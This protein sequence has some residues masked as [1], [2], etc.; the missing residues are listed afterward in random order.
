LDGLISPRGFQTCV[1]LG[2]TAE[3]A[4]VV[5]RVVV[6]RGAQLD[7]EFTRAG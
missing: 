4:R 5:S 6:A 7:A 3:G 1:E 2:R